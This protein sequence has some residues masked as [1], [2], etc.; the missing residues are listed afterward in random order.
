MSSNTDSLSFGRYLKSVR[1]EQQLTIEQIA[2]ETRIR[3]EYLLLLEE[4]NYEKL[5]AEVF[6]KGFLRAYA[7]A[8]GINTD[9]IIQRYIANSAS[10]YA[11]CQ[12]IE[13]KADLYKKSK[14]KM[15]KRALLYCAV[16]CGIALCTVIIFFLQGKKNS[17][18]RFEQARDDKSIDIIHEAETQNFDEQPEIALLPQKNEEVN[19][20]PNEAID[21][22]QNTVPIVDDVKVAEKLLLK[23]KAI[24]KTWMRIVIDGSNSKEYILNAGE[25]LQLEA[26]SNFAL[27]I[28]NAAGVTLT[29]NDKPVKALG[30]RGQVVNIHLP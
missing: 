20:A 7:K 5:P 18:V 13:T 21:D 2:N 24:E 14:E 15:R 26:L 19:E 28:G 27:T 11:S 25:S 23:V 9:D 10:Y 3:P 16:L 29:L 22:I 6:V 30:R 1:I 4:E 12:P 8:M 17:S